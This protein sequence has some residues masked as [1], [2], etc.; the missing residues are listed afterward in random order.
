[1]SYVDGD[2]R[3]LA[4]LTDLSLTGGLVDGPDVDLMRDYAALVGQPV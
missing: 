2:G 1:M 3:E 4:R